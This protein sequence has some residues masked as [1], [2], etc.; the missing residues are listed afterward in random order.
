MEKLAGLNPVT[1][2]LDFYKG[3][4]VFI[5]GHTGFKGSW[6]CRALLNAGASVTGYALA[7]ATKPALFDILRLENDMLSVVGDIRGFDAL[8]AALKS[9]DPEIVFHMAA[10]PIVREGY[11]LPVYTYDVNVMGS[12]NLLEAARSVSGLASLV[13]VT[14]DKV[15]EN[16][17]QEKGY[18][19]TDS[20]CGSDPYSSSK[21]C[22]ELVTYAYKK[23]FFS[24]PHAP[25]VSTARSGNVI[26]GGDF[27]DF[28][29]IPDCVRAALANEP[30]TIRNPDSIRPYQH[31]LDCLSGYLLLARMQAED[32]GYAGQY[33]FG[34]EDT[35]SVTNETLVKIFCEAWGDGASYDVKPDGG[36]PE[37]NYLRLDITKSKTILSWTPT[38]NIQTAIK[39]TVSWEKARVEGEAIRETDKQIDDFFKGKA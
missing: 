19:E 17:E 6:L 4:R 3:K 39:Q 35:D 28:R 30:V 15:Y 38:W 2:L 33:N 31:V 26:G 23:S 25:S 22:S 24:N 7:P 16:K 36:P 37:T 1:N 5:T 34:P 10:Q 21:S 9:A 8:S 32:G 20:L 14:T 27:A 29:I 18:V 12:V 11:D 13:N